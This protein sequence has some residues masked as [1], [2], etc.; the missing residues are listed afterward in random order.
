MKRI[1][2]FWW[3]I[4][5]AALAMLRLRC[6]PVFAWRLATADF[7]GGLWEEGVSPREALD[8]ELSYWKD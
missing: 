3:R 4:R 5:F 6:G 7:D 8:T 2:I 1:A